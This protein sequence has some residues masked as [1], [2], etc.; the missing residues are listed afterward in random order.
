MHGSIVTFV[1]HG[2]QL[3]RLRAGN[4]QLSTAQG[5]LDFETDG[6]KESL[7]VAGSAKRSN[8][9]PPEQIYVRID[10][11]CECTV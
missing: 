1:I 5:S 2:A 4:K 8:P 7:L 10:G 6:M 9:S 11:Q 3:C